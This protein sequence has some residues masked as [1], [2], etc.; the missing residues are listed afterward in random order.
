MDL[1]SILKND[2]SMYDEQFAK[3]VDMQVADFEPLKHANS[4]YIA[5]KI[6][7]AL[8]AVAYTRTPNNR[9]GSDGKPESYDRQRNIGSAALSALRTIASTPENSVAMMYVYNEYFFPRVISDNRKTNLLSNR[10]ILDLI[11]QDAKLTEAQ[12]IQ[13]ASQNKDMHI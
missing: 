10:S 2:V 4:D 1:R 13:M 7:P 8:F 5:S 9:T 12:N 3:S 6:V 11:R